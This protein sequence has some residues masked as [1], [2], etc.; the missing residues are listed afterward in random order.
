MRTL[1]LDLETVGFDANNQDSLSPYKGQIVSL[2]MYDLERALGSVYFVN[3]TE[4]QQFSDGTFDFKPHTEKAL[5]Q[6]F[7]D[8]VREYDVLVSF[9]GRAFDLP[10]IYIRSL[11]HEIKP[12]VHLSRQRYVTKQ[13]APYHV[14]L[15]DEFSFHGAVTR[16]PSLESLCQAVGIDNPKQSMTGEDITELFLDKQVDEIAKYNAGDVVAITKLYDK[17]LTS[18]APVQFLNL[19]QS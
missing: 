4:A 13:E 17:W 6:D 8:T 1:I 5:L 14:D 10:F 7:W 18:L 11:A 19:L 2:G 3:Q 9:N 12:S 16:K 15:F